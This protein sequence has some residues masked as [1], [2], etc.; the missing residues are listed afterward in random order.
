VP[1]DDQSGKR[2]QE[3]RKRLGLTQQEIADKAGVRREMWSRYERGAAAPGAAVFRVLA[4][5]GMDQLYI[6]TGTTVPPASQP[7]L[8]EDEMELIRLFRAA[9]LQ[10]KAAVLGALT[11]GGAAD[12]RS[13]TSISVAGSGNRVAGKDYYEK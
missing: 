4:E 8:S 11:A 9:P 12:K 13:D 3:E 6:L 5:L 10:V 7:R 2:L 1:F